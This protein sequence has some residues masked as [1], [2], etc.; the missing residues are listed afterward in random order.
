MTKHDLLAMVFS[1]EILRYYMLGMKV[2]MHTD[3][4]SLRYLMV[5]KDVKPRL[6]NWVL[7]FQEFEFEIKI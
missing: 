4:A 2:I 7:L 6:I 1:F 3:Q 5:K